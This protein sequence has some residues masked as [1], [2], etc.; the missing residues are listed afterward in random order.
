MGAERHPWKP[1]H[2][3]QPGEL[4]PLL[5]QG[6]CVQPDGSRVLQEGVLLTLAVSLG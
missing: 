3:E 4:P 6:K 2:H 1:L 5:P